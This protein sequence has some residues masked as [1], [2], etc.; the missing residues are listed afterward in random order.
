MKVVHR[1]LLPLRRRI[2]N[3]CQKV[4]RRLEIRVFSITCHLEESRELALAEKRM[5]GREDSL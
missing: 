3:V 2:R 5:I 1:I 4:R